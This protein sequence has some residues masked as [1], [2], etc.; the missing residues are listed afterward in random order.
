[1]Q[2]V[3][4]PRGLCDHNPLGPQPDQGR[5]VFADILH[6]TWDWQ[7]FFDDLR[8]NVSGIAVSHLDS[9]LLGM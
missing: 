3:A 2:A 7:Q 8:L 1:M 5:P 9:T 6:G 4:E